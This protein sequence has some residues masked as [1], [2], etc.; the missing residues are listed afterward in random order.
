MMRAKVAT[1]ST[2]TTSQAKSLKQELLR[3]DKF[4]LNRLQK[5]SRTSANAITA[6][7]VNDRP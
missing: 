4:L 7:A 6:G 3:L 2:S 1:S 5:T